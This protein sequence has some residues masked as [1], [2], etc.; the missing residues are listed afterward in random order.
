[1]S[2]FKSLGVDYNGVED[3][4]SFDDGKLVF[5]RSCA[6]VEPVIEKNK[7]LQTAGNNGYTPSRDLQHVANVP[8]GLVEIWRQQYGVDP[9]ARENRTLLARL[10]NDSELRHLRVGGGT[11]DFK[12]R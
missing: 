1:M 10:L 4:V 2:E 12:D 5:K 9:L 8:F 7:A 6:D 11:L 3:S